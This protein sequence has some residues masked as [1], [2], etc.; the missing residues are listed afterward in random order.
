MTTATLSMTKA[1]ERWVKAKR[2]AAA[3]EAEL[4]ATRSVILQWFRDRPEKR[5]Y[6]GE[7]GYAVTVS[8]ILDHEKVKAHLG[9]DLPK[10]QKP[11][12]RETLSLLAP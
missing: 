2:A 6:R 9:K 11:S 7:V 10:F 3:A 12:R 1:V 8:Q 5:D 4:E